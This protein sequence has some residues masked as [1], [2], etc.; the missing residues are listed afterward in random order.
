MVVRVAREIIPPFV[1]VLNADFGTGWVRIICGV[2]SERFP[3][4]S[5]ERLFVVGCS[6]NGNMTREYMVYNI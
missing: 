2:I 3:F 1:D 5:K 6:L 4:V